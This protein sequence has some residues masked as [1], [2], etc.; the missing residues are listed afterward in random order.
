MKETAM[1]IVNE[2]GTMYGLKSALAAVWAF[3]AGAVG[4]PDSAAKWLVMLMLA[5]FALGFFRAWKC[6][7][8]RAGK[9][10]S[11]AFKFFWYWLTVAVFM[12]VDEAVRIA[13]PL[14]PVNLRDVFI[15]YLAVNEAFSCLD[16]LA[17][18]RMPMPKP[19]I[20]R[21]RRYRHEILTS[22][23]DGVERKS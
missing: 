14:V 9:L 10:K 11:G 3:I 6:R 18:F 2:L 12:W 13:V 21:L 17:F 1:N 8:I 22:P 16:H 5:D 23:W 7:D 19:F 4:H 15:A 20:R